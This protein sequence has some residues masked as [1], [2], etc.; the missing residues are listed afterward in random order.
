MSHG[1]HLHILF[2]CN[3]RKYQRKLECCLFWGGLIHH[4]DN[5]GTS[6]S[7]FF[8]SSIFILSPESSVPNQDIHLFPIHII[9]L[10]NQSTNDFLRSQ[11]MFSIRS[12][13]VKLCN[14]FILC[15][16]CWEIKDSCNAIK[17]EKQLLHLFT[18]FVY[19]FNIIGS[20]T[21]L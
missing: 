8:I 1:H 2:I 18:Y 6:K 14:R 17:W 4:F 13:K 10:I 3:E 20:Y 21:T 11:R 7:H 9:Y 15:A 12:G 16:L 5:R 19:L